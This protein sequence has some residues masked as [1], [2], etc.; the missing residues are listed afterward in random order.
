[1]DSSPHLL[2]LFPTNP[3]P[4][5]SSSCYSTSPPAF[6]YLLCPVRFKTAHSFSLPC[7]L[8]YPLFLSPGF[9]Q[10]SRP[11]TAS[12]LFTSSLSFCY[13]SCRVAISLRPVISPSV[14]QLSFFF[15]PLAYSPVWLF[16]PVI[17]KRVG[18][19]SD[20]SVRYG[21]SWFFSH[22]FPSC[23][24]MRPYPCVFLHTLSPTNAFCP[25]STLF[26]FSPRIPCTLGIGDFLLIRK[27]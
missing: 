16:C 4:R 10:E 21:V 13:D 23:L 3:T 14:P 11:T 17:F 12:F 9:H 15:P 5:F 18:S 25:S 7:S 20:L 19:S 26:L 24:W 27:F 6:I 2:L 1:L 8:C 22:S